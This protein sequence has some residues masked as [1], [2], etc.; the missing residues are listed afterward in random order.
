MLRKITYKYFKIKQSIIKL[1]FLGFIKKILHISRVMLFDY[2]MLYIYE[3]DIRKDLEDIFPTIEVTYRL[4]TIEDI[5]GMDSTHG[6]D[7]K[8]KEY[9]I[10]RLMKGDE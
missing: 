7:K 6:Y 9:M 8:D 4:A 10:N 3:L 1:G 5:Q 2:N